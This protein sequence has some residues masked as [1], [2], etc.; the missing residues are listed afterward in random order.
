M[1]YKVSEHIYCISKGNHHSMADI[2][3]CKYCLESS[4]S[5]PR[6]EL[7]TPCKCTDPV[8]V[9]CLQE[10]II[11]TKK[12]EC[13]ICV[14]PFIVTNIFLDQIKDKIDNGTYIKLLNAAINNKLDNNV[15]NETDIIQL[16]NEN[17]DLLGNHEIPM[18]EEDNLC[19]KYK[20]MI[21]FVVIIGLLWISMII[22][23]ILWKN[24]IIQMCT[25]IQFLL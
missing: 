5:N 16:F 3:M 22:Y 18:V 13:E 14:S 24:Q 21:I 15:L 4:N 9:A 7:I 11:K 10:Q 1:N 19:I 6:I 8:C 23:G 2:I 20:K 25:S 12:I 17:N